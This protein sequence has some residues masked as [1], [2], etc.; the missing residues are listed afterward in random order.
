MLHEWQIPK[1]AII[2]AVTDGGSNIK[3]VVSI[4]QLKWFYCAAHMVH[5]AIQNGLV[6]SGLKQLIKP[7][8]KIAHYFR[9]SN[10]AAQ[11]VSGCSQCKNI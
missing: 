11:E 6:S 2:G 7:A 3:K 1:E 9:N 10:K 5:C 8:K 4:L